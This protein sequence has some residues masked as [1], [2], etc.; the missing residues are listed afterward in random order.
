MLT[1]GRSFSVIHTKA[2]QSFFIALKA[3]C[4]LVNQTIID[5]W[6]IQAGLITPRLLT[7]DELVVRTQTFIDEFNR[8]LSIVQSYLMENISTIS[9]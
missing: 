7:Q 6:K 5:A 1:Q 4:A 8:I 3:F 2:I 9:K